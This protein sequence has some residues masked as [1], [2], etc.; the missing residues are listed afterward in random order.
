MKKLRLLSLLCILFV[1]VGCG[2]A[3]QENQFD[4]TSG[5]EGYFEDNGDFREG[6]TSNGEMDYAEENGYQV[7]VNVINAKEAEI[8]IQSP[9]FLKNT[10]DLMT[11][12]SDWGSEIYFNSMQFGIFSIYTS[13]YQYDNTQS[14]SWDQME[15]YLNYCEYVDGDIYSMYMF[16]MQNYS[17][18][19]GILTIHLILPNENETA[20]FESSNQEWLQLSDE[21]VAEIN[22]FSIQ[23]V[24]EFKFEEY[25]Y[26]DDSWFAYSMK[27]TDCVDSSQSA[28]NN[29]IFPEEVYSTD[30]LITSIDT[31]GFDT[32]DSN[33]AIYRTAWGD[34]TLT[35]EFVLQMV[36]GEQG[37]LVDAI[38]RIVKPCVGEG[39]DENGNF[40]AIAASTEEMLDYAQIYIND[41][42]SQTDIDNLSQGTYCA[43]DDVLFIHMSAS[44]ITSYQN[45]LE[46]YG[47]MYAAQAGYM[48]GYPLL[49]IKDSSNLIF[50]SDMNFDL[51]SIHVENYCSIDSFHYVPEKDYGSDD[52]VIR[53]SN[54]DGQI[55]G[56]VYYYDGEQ[57]IAIVEYLNSNGSYSMRE[58][59][60]DQIEGTYLDHSKESWIQQLKEEMN[61]TLYPE[62][63][64]GEPSYENRKE[65]GAIYVAIP[66][67]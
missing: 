11:D 14:L 25:Q 4:G 37:E 13:L 9:I 64:F 18:Q 22:N 34:E 23:N 16:T 38:L 52:F 35:E 21:Q 42:Y 1:L 15:C 58:V 65:L 60:L 6:E 67:L 44:D 54:F 40:G 53:E 50:E 12:I 24:D 41:S 26:N 43:K 8:V 61:G 39:Y 36:Y 66:E 30:M 56:E 28:E 5:D 27:A 57:I 55:S 17:I 31:K 45:E 63:E 62:V 7:T 59:E 51:S 47:Y 20:Q 3:N 10:E 48:Y 19:D 46:D 32:L 33:Y 29:A 49:D 2:A